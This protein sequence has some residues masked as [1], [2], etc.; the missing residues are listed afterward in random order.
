MPEEFRQGDRVRVSAAG[1]EILVNRATGKTNPVWVGRRGVVTRTPMIT[2][3][4]V[5]VQ[6]DDRDTPTHV[7]RAVIEK[8]PAAQKPLSERKAG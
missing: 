4:N 3:K 8:E 5:S 1:M 7:H 6:F 2:A